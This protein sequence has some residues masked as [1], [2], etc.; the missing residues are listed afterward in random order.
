MCRYRKSLYMCNHSQISAEPM[1][2]CQA[3]REYTSGTAK[4]PCDRVETHPRDT[5]RVGLLCPPCRDKKSTLDKQL[6]VVKSR[7]AELRKY[8]DESY[9][10][11]MKHL[12]EAGLE[13]E[14]KP[15]NG[16]STTTTTTAE[17]RKGK[18]K[19]KDPEP[20]KEEKAVDPVQEFLRKKMMDTDAHLMMLSG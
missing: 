6:D 8:L 1:A 10:D 14:E 13:P 7:M 12:D 15:S 9:G 5:I 20:A 18:G 4:E 3:Q 2:A 17:T 19:G 11:C 16:K